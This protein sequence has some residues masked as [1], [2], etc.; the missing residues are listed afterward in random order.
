MQ[1]LLPQ[2]HVLAYLHLVARRYDHARLRYQLEELEL[3]AA[4]GVRDRLMLEPPFRG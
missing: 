3:L 4:D 2:F 1:Y